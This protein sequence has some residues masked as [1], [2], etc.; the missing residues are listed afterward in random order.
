[1]I[2]TFGTESLAAGGAG[3]PALGPWDLAVIAVSGLA[4]LALAV[5]LTA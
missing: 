3:E 2:D 1:M 5:Y 4:L